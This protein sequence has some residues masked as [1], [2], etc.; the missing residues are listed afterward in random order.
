ME[1]VPE[2]IQHGFTNSRSDNGM[3][4]K[5]YDR[6]LLGLAQFVANMMDK[7]PGD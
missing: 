5:N 7:I 2:G 6:F 3:D 4:S 1:C